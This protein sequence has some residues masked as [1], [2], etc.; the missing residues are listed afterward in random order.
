MMTTQGK[1]GTQLC[2][3]RQGEGAMRFWLWVREEHASS[4]SPPASP[5]RPDRRAEELF[6]CFTA[7]RT[8]ARMQLPSPNFTPQTSPLWTPTFWPS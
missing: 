6:H 1:A 2:P 4:L 8:N 7:D 5:Q 3:S